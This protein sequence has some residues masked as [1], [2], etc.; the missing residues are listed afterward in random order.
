MTATPPPTGVPGEFDMMAQA[1]GRLGLAELPPVERVSFRGARVSLSALR[2]GR[3]DPRVVLLHGGGQNA[4]TWDGVLFRLGADALAVDLPGHGRSGWYDHPPYLPSDHA[5]DLA[6]V[7]EEVRPDLVVGMSMGG[8]AIIAM[9]GLRPDLLARVILVDVSPGSTPDRS[10]HITT[11]TDRTVFDSLDEMVRHTR[12]FRV[13]PDEESL[14]RSVLYNARP[15]GD[16]RWTW[17][18]DRRPPPSGGDRMAPIFADLPRYWDDVARLTCPTMVVLGERSPIVH[19]EDV[20]RY[21]TLVP[22]ITV[23]TV[24]GAGHNVQGD[25]PDELAGLIAGFAA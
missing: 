12:T 7:L 24:P 14:R 16:G 20:A 19:A 15:L 1:A 3:G 18:G 22:G 6:P 4:H 25:A 5:A 13:G 21:R 9:A 17:R 2:W 10:T 23:V 11:F 8:L